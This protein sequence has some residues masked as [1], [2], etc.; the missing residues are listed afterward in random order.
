MISLTLL[1]LYQLA[2]VICS[3]LNMEVVILLL[4]IAIWMIQINKK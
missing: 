1:S 2:M 4:L 3:I